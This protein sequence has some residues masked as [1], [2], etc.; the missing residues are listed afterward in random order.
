MTQ[1]E[2]KHTRWLESYLDRDGY[3]IPAGLGTIDEACSVAAIRLAW[4]GKLSDTPPPCMSY[5]IGR[6]IIKPV[7]TLRR[8]IEC[9]M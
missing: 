6:W 1:W 2:P 5:H 4:D 3:T 7:E 8:L 9:R